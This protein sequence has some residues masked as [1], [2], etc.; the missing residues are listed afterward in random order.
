VLDA[1]FYGLDI[2][3]LVNLKRTKPRERW[4]LVVRGPLAVHLESVEG[5]G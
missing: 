5:M 2:P 4:M 3:L 1:D